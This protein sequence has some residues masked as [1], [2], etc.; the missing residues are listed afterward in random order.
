MIYTDP[1]GKG[2]IKRFLKKMVKNTIKRKGKVD[3]KNDFIETFQDYAD[4]AME[5]GDGTWNQE[6]L[7]TAFELITDV[8]ADE[9]KALKG[10]MRTFFKRFSKPRNKNKRFTKS[11]RTK[12]SNRRNRTDSND[13]QYEEISNEQNRQR[14]DKK[15]R[16]TKDAD[17]EWEG[18]SSK[19]KSRGIESTKKSKQKKIRP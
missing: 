18:S 8:E 12:K 7:I 11:Q 10:G 17:S 1:N 4:A 14:K 6:D 16:S 15:G 5:F 13:Q 3:L 19:P 9:L 2:P